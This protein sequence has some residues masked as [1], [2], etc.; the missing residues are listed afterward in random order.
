MKGL[1]IA[2]YVMTLIASVLI[3]IYIGTQVI[4]TTQI[5][6]KAIMVPCAEPTPDKYF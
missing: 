5:I 6:N 1:T 2:A 3:G 4:P